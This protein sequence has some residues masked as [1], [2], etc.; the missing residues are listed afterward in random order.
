MVSIHLI[1]PFFYAL[2]MSWINETLKLDWCKT[3]EMLIVDIIKLCNFTPC[4]FYINTLKHYTQKHH[5]DIKY[6]IFHDL[7]EIYSFVTDNFLFIMLEKCFSI[8]KAFG[9]VG[10]LLWIL[11]LYQTLWWWCDGH[12]FSRFSQEVGVPMLCRPLGITKIAFVLSVYI[13]AVTCPSKLKG[14]KI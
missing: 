1:F 8:A 11:E 6:S 13:F 4:I 10:E 3:C 5:K 9:V 7:I 12:A 2:F 14:G